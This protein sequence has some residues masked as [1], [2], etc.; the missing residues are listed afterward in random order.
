MKTLVAFV[1]L[2]YI[3]KGK[4]SVAFPY[5]GMVVAPYEKKF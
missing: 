4:S 1:D 2:A 5:A 3:G